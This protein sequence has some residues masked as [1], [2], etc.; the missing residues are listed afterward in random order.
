MVPLQRSHLEYCRSDEE[1]K[2][3]LELEQ[4][5]QPVARVHVDYTTR[6]GVERLHMLLP[7]EAEKLQQTPFAVIQVCQGSISCY[8]VPPIFTSEHVFAA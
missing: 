3:E 5:G 8:L 4:R 6:S 7:D 1:K 2:H